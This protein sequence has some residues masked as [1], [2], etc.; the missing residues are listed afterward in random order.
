MRNSDTSED[1]FE[2]TFH[3]APLF[4]VAEEFPFLRDTQRFESMKIQILI[5]FYHSICNLLKIICT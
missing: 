1:A 2:E 3:F 5:L 4:S